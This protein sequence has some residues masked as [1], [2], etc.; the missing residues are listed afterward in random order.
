MTFQSLVKLYYLNYKEGEKNKNYVE[1]WLRNEYFKMHT[2]STSKIYILSLYILRKCF[3]GLSLFFFLVYKENIK[4]R[5]LVSLNKETTNTQK[6]LF[7]KY[8]MG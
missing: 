3:N 5:G 7:G 8:I 6:Q 1:N 2:F 4:I